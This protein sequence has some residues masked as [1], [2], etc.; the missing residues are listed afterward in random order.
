[1]REWLGYSEA[2]HSF[3][4]IS[5]IVYWGHN[6]ATEARAITALGEQTVDVVLRVGGK[7]VCRPGEWNGQRARVE[8]RVQRGTVEVLARVTCVSTTIFVVVPG[9]RD[10]EGVRLG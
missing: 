10:G 2:P 9:K 6:Q 3:W 8:R 1:M 4:G 7:V 5:L